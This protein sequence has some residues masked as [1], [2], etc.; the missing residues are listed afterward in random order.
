MIRRW[1]NRLRSKFAAERG[2]TLVELMASILIGTLA[3]ALLFGSSMTAGKIDQT[4]Q[5]ADAAHYA[6]LSAA[7]QQ[8]A[9]LTLSPPPQVKISNPLNGMTKQLDIAGCGDEGLYAYALKTNP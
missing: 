8:Q 4:T 9:E 3:I 1:K 7:E 2:E 6:S 5:A